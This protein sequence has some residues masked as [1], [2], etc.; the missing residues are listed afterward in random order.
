MSLQSVRP[1]GGIVPCLHVDVERQYPSSFLES[2]NSG[3]KIVRNARAE[4]GAQSKFLRLLEIKMESKD[5]QRDEACTESSIVEKDRLF[6]EDERKVS[7]F[8][9][10]RVS[11]V[12]YFPASPPV[13]A[14]L[15]VWGIDEE[16]L[17]LF[18]EG[19]RL[20]LL[21]VLV[22]KPFGADTRIRLSTCRSSAA[23]PFR[24]SACSMYAPRANTMFDTLNSLKIKEEFDIVAC[25]IAV[26][27]PYES[28]NRFLSSTARQ[29]FFA[30]PDFILA[31]ECV[32]NDEMMFSS[33]LF[34]P[35]QLFTVCN[36]Q[37]GSYHERCRVANA[38]VSRETVF[39]TKPHRSMPLAESFAELQLWMQSS[40][41]REHLAKCSQ[42]VTALL[43]GNVLDD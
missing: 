34:R 3:F 7:A 31:V 9:Q 38:T 43:N 20:K 10:V 39:S 5:I 19:H 12:S 28:Q 29:L 41:G 27:E 36:L 1:D 25:L 22:S 11:E 8:F 32:E 21:G 30:T 33:Q 35:N 15:R 14:V 17:H 13:S 18:S 37:C 40:I 2:A 23:L 24:S 42:R 4:D 6:A 16:S 26:G